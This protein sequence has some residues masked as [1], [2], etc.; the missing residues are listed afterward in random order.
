MKFSL[1]KSDLL[2]ALSLVAKSVA[3]K[4][5]TPI[6]SG[7]FIKCEN[8]LIELQ[9][10][11]FSVGTIARIPAYAETTGLTCVSGKRLAEI[12]PKMPDDTISFELVGNKFKIESGA[13][14]FELLTFDPDD[15]PQVKAA[16]GTELKIPAAM[17]KEIVARVASAA[18]KDDNRPIFKG[19]YFEL[20]NG[21]LKAV[22]TNAHRINYFE[23]KI[24]FSGEMNM[25]IPASALK[26]L[27]AALP[28]DA[29]PV[30]ITVNLKD[31]TFQC[32]NFMTTARQIA[33]QFPPYEKILDVKENFSLKVNREEFKGAINRMSMIAKDSEFNGIALGIEEGCLTVSAKTDTT[34]AEEC[35]EIDGGGDLRI[36]FNYKYLQ[37]ML[38]AISEEFLQIGFGGEYEPAKF[39]GFGEENFVGII[40]PLRMRD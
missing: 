28:N 33:G 18:G 23:E 32:S 6:L 36:G 16:E 38:S 27:A 10:N 9:A 31:V 3:L 40:T 34:A 22:A 39:Q 37:D 4:P 29:T 5:S 8:S 30:K 1:Y 12:V 11:N 14:K 13:A 24:E 26:D 35:L 21:T 2:S 15:F 17:L 20:S 19:V 25:L 7:I